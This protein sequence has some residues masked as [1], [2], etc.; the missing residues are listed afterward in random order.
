[1]R[2]QAFVAPMMPIR[3]FNRHTVVAPW[4]RSG[5][6]NSTMVVSPAYAPAPG[7]FECGLEM[8]PEETV[9]THAPERMHAWVGTLARTHTGLRT[10]APTVA[11]AP[12]PSSPNTHTHTPTHTHI[13][14]HTHTRAR[15][16]ARIH[17]YTHTPTH[18]RARAHRHTHTQPLGFVS[19]QRACH[20]A[21]TVSQTR[22]STGSRSARL[23]PSRR[24]SS[25][26]SR[27][28]R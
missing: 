15:T 17:A 2:D 25:R 27:R 18:T 4:H 21:I 24:R 6:S 3:P 5:Y 11:H 13:H 23:R 10:D 9:S 20:F 1:M 14:T 28:R 12:K 26:C 7:G 19:L 8:Q 22:F 16:H